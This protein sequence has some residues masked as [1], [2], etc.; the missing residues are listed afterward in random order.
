MN[1]A[2]SNSD[3]SATPTQGRHRVGAGRAIGTTV[4]RWCDAVAASLIALGVTPNMLTAAGTVLTGLASVFLIL[5]AGHAPVWEASRAIGPSSL[6]PLWAAI[7][8]TVAFACDLLDGAVARVGNQRTEFGAFLDSTLDR[9]SD[10]FIFG[11]CAI[12]FAYTGNVTYA[13]LSI[14]AAAN[15]VLI[16]YVKARAENFVDDCGVGYWQ[17]GERC[18][19]FLAGAYFGHI[20]AALWLLGTLPITTVI[21]RIV[22]THLLLE[23]SAKSSGDTG[24]SSSFHDAPAASSPVAGDTPLPPSLNKGGKRDVEQNRATQR[25]LILPTSKR[26]P[27]GSAAYDVCTALALAFIIAAPLLWRALST[28]HDPLGTLLE[29]LFAA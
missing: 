18:G 24:R 25:T 26:L 15:G 4:G 11:G 19:L 21:H 20:P 27:R 9:F 7:V 8:L 5:G 12:H 17:R 10:L 22:R 6:W 29:R 16:S 28:T 13:A 23:H 3:T 14:T 2:R 1:D